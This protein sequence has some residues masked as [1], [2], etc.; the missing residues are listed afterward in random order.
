MALTEKGRQLLDVLMDKETSATNALTSK[1]IA[2]LTGL[3][4]K[5]V[6]GSLNSL[7]KKGLV[8]KTDDKPRLFY[9]SDDGLNYQEED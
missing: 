1:D 7:V 8:N 6:P 9:I 5:S 3:P 2:E 4:V